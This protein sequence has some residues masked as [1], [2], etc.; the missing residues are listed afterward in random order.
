[1]RNALQIAATAT[2]I[3]FA[4]VLFSSKEVVGSDMD[5]SILPGD[6]IWISPWATPLPGDVVLLQDPLDPA[7]FILR[8]VLAIGGQTIRYD[9]GSIRVGARRLRKQAMGDSDEHLVAQETL[10]AKKPERGHQWL[11][12][13]L[14]YPATRWSAEPVTV[15]DGYLYVLADNRD[16]AVDSRWWGSIPTT[17]ALG[18]VRFRLGKKHKWRP[19]WEWTVGTAPIRE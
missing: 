14:A 11:T 13:Q 6:R 8:R 19:D 4:A 3:I 16:K 15:P 1:M 9:E 2:L 10:W 12:Q 17:A 7:F 5:P 18:V